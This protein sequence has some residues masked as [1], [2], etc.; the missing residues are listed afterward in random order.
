MKKKPIEK[1]LKTH[2]KTQNTTWKLTHKI[3]GGGN[4]F[5]I[6][7]DSPSQLWLPC[8]KGGCSYFL[9]SK[10]NKHSPV[11]QVCQRWPEARQCMLLNYQYKWHSVSFF[12]LGHHR[13]TLSKC[14]LRGYSLWICE[15]VGQVSRGRLWVCIWIDA[16]STVASCPRHW[17]DRCRH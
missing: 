2:E 6:F 16:R 14:E 9:P 12:L 4:P 15:D 1:T 10:K 13:W 11:C 7:V 5:V 17:R 8:I 3:Q